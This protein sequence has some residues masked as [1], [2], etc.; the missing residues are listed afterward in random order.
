MNATVNILCYRSK[1]LSNGENPLMIR[2]CK[3]GKK[4]YQSLGVSVKPEYWDFDKNQPK[5]N[6]PNRDAIIQIISHKYNEFT[7]QIFEFKTSNKDYTTSVLVERVNKPIK[8]KTVKE[9]FEEQI[10]RLFDEKRRGYALSH[11]QFLNS[12]IA[13][14]KH[15]DNYFSDID[16]TW[17]RKYE[18]WLRGNNISTNTIGVRFRTLRAVFNVAIK[19]KIVKAE[20]YPFE[21]YNV[22][23]LR[24]ETVKRS[25]SKDD[26]LSVISYPYNEENIYEKLSIN[27][28]TFS[29]LMAGINFVD[30]AYLTCVNIIE[31][32]LVYFRKKT[33]KL[34]KTPLQ[35]KAMA[36]ISKYHSNENP[37]LLAILSAI[38]LTLS[39]SSNWVP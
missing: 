34:I 17:L 10:Q 38:C 32:C 29:Y 14:N 15:L 5:R 8:A 39:I 35:T 27:L 1:K 13:F 37:Y 25:I 3:D 24:Q 33:N 26:I 20:Y 23:K 9:V 31:N 11:K 12:L 2:I 36:I 22:S 28:F 30:I 18:T 19:E 21:N 16:I 7:N 6:C 4:K